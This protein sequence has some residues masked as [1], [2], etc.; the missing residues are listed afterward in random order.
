MPPVT[1]PLPVPPLSEALSSSQQS[2]DTEGAK[3][4]CS[5][6]TFDNYPALKQCE[7]C[8]MPRIPS[9]TWFDVTLSLLS[10]IITE[11]VDSQ[12]W[13]LVANISWS[14]LVIDGKVESSVN[15]TLS[16]QC[17]S[18]QLFDT[19]GWPVTSVLHLAYK[20]T[21]SRLNWE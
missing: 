13:P 10:S 19:I 2:D 4:S 9:S 14:V 16:V 3:W 6:C 11:S 7:I 20:T 21:C 1:C 12:H 18:V 5:A 8:E 15:T 17:S